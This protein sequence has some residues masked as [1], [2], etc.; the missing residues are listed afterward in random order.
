M[1]ADK[2]HENVQTVESAAVA[3]D[4]GT[5]VS[6]GT[7]KARGGASG[8]TAPRRTATRRTVLAACGCGIG[9]LIVGGVLG[10]WGIDEAKAK[11]GRL[12]IS[13]TPTK[14]IVTDRGRCSGC[15]RCELMCSL[16]NDGVAMQSTARV[17]VH[18]TYF[19]G[20]SPDGIDGT[21]DNF[22]YTIKSC[23]Q[24]S[25][26][27][28]AKFCPANAIYAD[29]ATGARMVDEERCLG[30]GMCTQACPW[31]MP[32]VSSLTGTSTKCIACGRCAEQCPNGAIQ[33]IDWED[34]AEE[35]LAHGI[36]ST[37]AVVEGA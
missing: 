34:I 32:R 3:G 21:Y 6:S 8:G 35:C 37:V 31:N 12:D 4:N 5:A 29:E 23:K 33:F 2:D 14:L 25:D 9:G 7:E 11:S 20:D 1:V 16:K 36:V 26:P 22:E 28:C 10:R 27:Q 17:R 15:Q 30:C 19:F 13:S 18:E 24:C